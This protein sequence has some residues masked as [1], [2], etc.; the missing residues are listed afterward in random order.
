M[1]ALLRELEAMAHNEDIPIAER[2]QAELEFLGY[3]SYTDA[4]R[5]DAGLV[6]NVDTKY[7]PKI[8]IYML[9]TGETVTY[10]LAKAA[11]QRNPFDKGQVI[12]FYSEERQKSKL[13][14]GVWVKDNNNLEPWITNYLIQDLC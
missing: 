2:L 3:I 11:H 9:A 6:L 8:T 10:K 5:N 1:D 12:R 4:S 13:V 7:S 14:D